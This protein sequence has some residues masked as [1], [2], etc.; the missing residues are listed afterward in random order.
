MNALKNT[1]R[2]GALSCALALIPVVAA[3]SQEAASKAQSD[4]NQVVTLSQDGLVNGRLV[5]IDAASKSASPLS[6]LDVYFVQDGSIIR[7]VVTDANGEFS[8]DGLTPG[9]YSFIGCGAK[10]FVAYGVVIQAAEGA[11]GD[12]SYMVAP[13]VSPRFIALREIVARYLPKKAPVLL[14]EVEIKTS[15]DSVESI[16]DGANRVQIREGKIYGT[17]RSLAADAKLAETKVFLVQNDEIISDVK[18][19]DSGAFE[20]EAVEPGVYDF[21]AVGP[22]GFSAIGFEAMQEPAKEETVVVQEG[23]AAAQESEQAQVPA[24]PAAELNS[25]LTPPADGQ[26]VAD[27]VEHASQVGGEVAV[28]EEFVPSGSALEMCGDAIGCGGAAGADGCGC[29]SDYFEGGGC[30]GGACCGGGTGFGGLAQAA[31]WAWVLTEL[32]DDD[33]PNNPPPVSPNN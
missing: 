23:A 3:V 6:E 30:G 18:A 16:A 17:V 15:L 20:F 7:S 13:V 21:I 25:L 4:R 27:Q 28:S 26:V 9:A 24:E 8:V 11:A 10:G 12:E 22:A 31:L 2:L 5:A 29:E 1:I 19:S 14:A 33:N 32:I